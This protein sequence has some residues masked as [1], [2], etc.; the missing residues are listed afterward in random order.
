MALYL[1]I[2]ASTGSSSFA[3]SEVAYWQRP[4]VADGDR[5][6]LR[7]LGEDLARCRVVRVRPARRVV[8][9]ADE[10]ADDVGIFL[11]VIGR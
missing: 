10:A 9:R 4:I 3:S 8:D 5:I 7:P 11:D 2:A 6:H 1:Y